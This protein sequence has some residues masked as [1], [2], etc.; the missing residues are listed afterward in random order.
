MLLPAIMEPK[1]K[2]SEC[3]PLKGDELNEQFLTK[4]EFVKKFMDFDWENLLRLQLSAEDNKIYYSP[5]LNIKDDYGRGVSVSIIG[6]IEE[7]EFY[8]CYKRPITRK[9]R[10]WFGLVEYEYYDKD[11]CSVTTEQTKKDGLAAFI[12]FYESNFDELGKRW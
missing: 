8:V 6:E 2:Y 9:K 10:K 5:S 12:L 3:H 7:Y 4:D 11:F 1:L